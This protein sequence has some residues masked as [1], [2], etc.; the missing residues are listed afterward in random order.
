MPARNAAPTA[1]V[2]CIAARRT[3]TADEVGLELAQEVITDAP[4]S[5]R[6]S[7][8]GVPARALVIASTTSAVWNAIDSTTARARCALPVPACDADDRPRARTRPTTGD[9]RPVNAGTT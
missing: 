7:A 5:M 4:P 9:P 3:G 2:S 6:I 8:G 1:V